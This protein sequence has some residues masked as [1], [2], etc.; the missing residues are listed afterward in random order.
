MQILY[1]AANFTKNK[2][3]L[4]RIYKISVRSILEHLAVVGDDGLTNKNY[5]T[6]NNERKE[7][8]FCK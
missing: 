3:D 4:K 8:S 5:E 1:K 7:T 2:Q 6:Y